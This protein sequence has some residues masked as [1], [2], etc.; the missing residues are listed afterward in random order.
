MKENTSQRLNRIMSERNLKQIDILELCKPYSEELGIK[1]ARN[2][3]SQYVN[4]IAEPNQNK[5]FLLAKALNVNEAWL[6]G[7]DVPKNPTIDNITN[8]ESCSVV[9]VPIIGTIACGTP[10]LADQNVIGYDYVSSDAI[11]GKEVFY[12][13]CK[14]DSMEPKIPDG[15]LVL[16][17][18]QP[19][20]EN[21]EIAAVVVNGDTE[22]TLKRVQF[23]GDTTILIAENSNYAPYII[24]K[25]NPAR[26]VGKAIQ[27]VTRL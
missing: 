27:V 10:L 15:S 8:I 12:L 11:K 1:I 24:N 26:I 6:M 13:E 16:V 19:T 4:G 21:G 7:Y 3:I 14:G 5:V 25:D 18:S 17:N 9:K 2:N 20:V 23:Q 22:A